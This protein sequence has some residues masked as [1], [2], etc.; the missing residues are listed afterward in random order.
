MRPHKYFFLSIGVRHEEYKGEEGKP[1]KRRRHNGM[2]SQ[3]RQL[4]FCYPAA[5]ATSSCI[6]RVLD[7]AHVGKREYLL[8]EWIG[9]SGRRI[10]AA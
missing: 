3:H 2:L 6:M 4:L 9:G 7:S 8:E 1:Q 5:A 10:A